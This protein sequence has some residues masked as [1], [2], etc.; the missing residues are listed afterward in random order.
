MRRKSRAA[1]D[2]KTARSKRLSGAIGSGPSKN[3]AKSPV[4]ST[5][6]MEEYSLAQGRGLEDILFNCRTGCRV[7]QKSL[8]Q[9]RDFYFLRRCQNILHGSCCLLLLSLKFAPDGF[10]FDI[11]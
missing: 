5:R 8:L 10:Q 9:C 6:F 3:E 1:V 7:Q 11:P 4:G 2:V